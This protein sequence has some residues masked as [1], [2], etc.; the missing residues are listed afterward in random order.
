ME[1]QYNAHP[2]TH[3]HDIINVI[4]YLQLIYIL[5]RPAVFSRIEFQKLHI[6]THRCAAFGAF[7]IFLL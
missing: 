6:E 5:E 1:S 2:H 3:I 4:L 7:V